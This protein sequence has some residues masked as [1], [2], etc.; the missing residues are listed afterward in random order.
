MKYEAFN[1]YMVVDK[2]KEAPK[3]IAGMEITETQNK[4]LRYFKGIVI[5]PGRF[6]D[7]IPKGTVIW[8]DR[9][10][11]HPIDIDNKQVFVIRVDDIA[12]ISHEIIS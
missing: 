6:G 8:Y 11:A 9:H 1:N 3:M 12:I 7:K 4:E 2:I 10:A 5:E